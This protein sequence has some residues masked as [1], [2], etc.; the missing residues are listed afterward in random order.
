M[1]ARKIHFVCF[2][3]PFPPTYGGAIDVFFKLQALV[4]EGLDVELHAFVYGNRGHQPKL[5]S[6][7]KKVHYYNRVFLKNPFM[8]KTPYIV[9]SRQVDTLLENLLRD[10]APIWFEGLHT[11]AFL[12]HPSLK[13]RKKYVRNHNIEADYY[14]HLAQSEK[15]FW[16]RQYFLHEAK[17]L[18]GWESVLQEATGVAAIS[19]NDYTTLQKR[20]GNAFYLPVFHQ[21]Q[22]V[23]VQEE[24]AE[25]CLY[26]G[27][28]A[29]AE[30]DEAAIFL[31]RKV[32]TPGMPP[33]HIAGN[34]A[35]NRLKKL[36]TE[37]SNVQLVEGLDTKTIMNK[38]CE[39]RVNVL[40]TFQPTGIKL[41]LLN[42]LFNGKHCVVSPDMVKG[43]GLAKTCKVGE[44]TAELKRLIKESYSSTFTATDLQIRIAALQP[45]DV[46]SNARELRSLLFPDG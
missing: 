35:S 36:V 44:T 16:K 40:P 28:L 7:V 46:K 25:Y 43:N 9:K 34:G 45:F 37:N 2:D 42:A 24:S 30:N 38:V 13:G 14:H 22:T 32:F 10:D 15:R 23:N 17:L 20:Y 21:N 3:V 4:H 18:A 33:L 5:E 19:P 11:T 6:L 1:S 41:K 12:G 26:H 29:V 39:T 27:N 31:V 8:G